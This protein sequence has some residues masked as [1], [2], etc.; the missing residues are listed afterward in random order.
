MPTY[1]Y[2]CANCD[3]KHEIQ[4]SMSD[5][6]LTVCP[7]CGES[8]LRKLFNNVGVVFKGSGFYRNDSRDKKSSASPAASSSK[9]EGTG[10]GSS[11]SS[12]SSGSSSSDSS[13]GSSSSGT[14]ATTSA[15]APSAPAA[16]SS[17]SSSA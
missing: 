3:T 4:Q 17:S 14:S 11:E 13:S 6:T 5:D 9:S 10:S 8:T 16:A 1:E 12:S 2:S 7:S 15:P